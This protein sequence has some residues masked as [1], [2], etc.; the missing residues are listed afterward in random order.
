MTTP[1][2]SRRSRGPRAAT[3][4]GTGAELGLGAVLLGITAL[5][6]VA[7]VHRPWPNRLDVWGY[8][9]L[10][11]AHHAHW[12]YDVTK[13]GSLT[14]LVVGVIVVFTIGIFRDWVRA[15]ACATAPV[16]AVLIVQDVAKPLVGRH[17]GL[18]GASSFPSGTV[19]AVAALSTAFVLV[20][21][22][23]LRPLVAVAGTAATVAASVAVI[24]V[25]WHYPT[26]ALG[27]IGVGIGAVLLMDAVL[28]IPWA[29]AGSVRSRPAEQ[30]Y[31][32][33]RHPRLA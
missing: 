19:A 11:A 20:V 17:I 4:A 13:L 7:F 12:A 6:G 31:Q 2:G 24:I 21:P 29:I 26:D 18:S 16:I 27:G 9:V 15:I 25:R 5:A 1:A 10:P 32:Q 22:A 28:H 8:R 14:A 3:A 23:L 33:Q 30:R